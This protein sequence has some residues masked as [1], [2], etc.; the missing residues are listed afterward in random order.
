MMNRATFMVAILALLLDG[1]GQAR[2][3]AAPIATIDGIYDASSTYGSGAYDTP[4][5][6]FHNTSSYDF[7]NAQVV[8]SGYQVGTLNYGATQTVSLGTMPS[9]MDS[10][11]IWTNPSYGSISMPANSVQVGP[12]SGDTFTPG[13]LFIND[14]DDSYGVAPY[15]VGNF[16]VTFTATL[17]GAG[18]LNG[19]PVFSV[20]SPTSNFTGGFV[21]W[22]GVDPNGYAESS[23]DAHNGTVSGT[24]AVIDI[25]TP[26]PSPEPATI[27]LLGI[28][29]AG[30]AG[31]GWRKRKAAVA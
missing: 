13:S 28:G 5:L 24:L 11:L 22:E 6:V 8:L 17:S 9:G 29:I 12:P 15:Q 21:G 27:T 20:F 18:S 7:I 3:L 14:Y 31:Y 4:T 19:S 16:S 30:M 1:L 26:P 25:G 2:L 10:V 23:Y